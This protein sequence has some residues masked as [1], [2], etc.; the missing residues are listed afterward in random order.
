M[1]NVQ[2]VCADIEGDLPV[3][4]AAHLPIKHKL[5]YPLTHIPLKRTESIIAS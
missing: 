4:V 5:L 3:L 1:Y 2:G